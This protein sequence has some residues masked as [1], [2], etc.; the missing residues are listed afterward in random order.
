[1]ENIVQF[2]A[3]V[4]KLLHDRCVVK[5]VSIHFQVVGNEYRYHRNEKNHF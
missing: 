3:L 5:R 4:V 1:M 2:H